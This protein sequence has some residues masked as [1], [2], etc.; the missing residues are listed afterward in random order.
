VFGE[1]DVEGWTPYPSGLCGHHD[2]L[3]VPRAGA[4]AFAAPA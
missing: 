3:G 2:S 4:G 1:C